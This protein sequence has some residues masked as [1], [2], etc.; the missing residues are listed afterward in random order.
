KWTAFPGNSTRGSTPVATLGD[1]FTIKRGLATGANAFFIL[2]RTEA[3]GRGIPEAFLKPILPGSRY[4]R[5][6][7]IE[8]SADGHPR[9]DRSLV[10]IDCDVPEDEI[11]ERHPGFWSYLQEGR[12]Q[13]IPAG[14]L[15]SRRSPWYSQE[16]RAPAP[17]LCTYM[18]RQ[19]ANGNPF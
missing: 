12:R 13:G 4:L 19:G 7:V 8:P 5:D 14:Y 6:P 3:R 11:R 16:K 17:F 10:L 1:F 9:L 2:E 18:G 15:A